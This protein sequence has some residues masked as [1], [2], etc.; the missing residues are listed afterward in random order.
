MS[1]KANQIFS[2]EIDSILLVMNTF[3]NRK[4]SK[5]KENQRYDSLRIDECN[6]VISVK[7]I[8]KNSVVSYKVNICDKEII[9][10]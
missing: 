3:D 4:T 10:L 5:E 8:N 6:A 1:S 2:V 9:K 7:N